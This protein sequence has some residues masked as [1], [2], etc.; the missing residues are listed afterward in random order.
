MEKAA[1]GRA[2][3]DAGT[4]PNVEAIANLS[5]WPVLPYT[6]PL[7]KDVQKTPI[8]CRHPDMKCSRI[9]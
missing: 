3:P 6:P 9:S 1:L 4:L 5:L 8:N 7:S 2:S